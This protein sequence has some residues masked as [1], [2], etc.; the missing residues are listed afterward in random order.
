MERTQNSETLS[1]LQEELL[2]GNLQRE[3]VLALLNEGTTPHRRGQS[4]LPALGVFGAVVCFTGLAVLVGQHWNELGSLMRIALT[5]GSGLIAYGVG[6]LLFLEKDAKVFATIAFIFSMLL[7]PSGLAV[8]LHE[9]GYNLGLDSCQLFMAVT[10]FLA[11]IAP[12]VIL[13]SN[14]MLV[15]AIAAGTAVFFVATDMLVRG[16]AV[17]QHFSEYRA[18][19]TGLFYVALG[20]VLREGEFRVT[21]AGLY[22]V[23]SVVALGAGFSLMQWKPNQNIVW[24]LLYPGLACAAIYGGAELR[25]RAIMVNGAFALNA[26]IIKI[27]VQYF[28]VSIG[29]PLTMI[30]T[31]AG[32]VGVALYASNLYGAPQYQAANTNDA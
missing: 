27:S 30:L 2:S 24:E 19:F 29:W 4:W 22:T 13:R 21:S 14:A 7:L 28:S 25:S 8:T 9:A 10:L 5:L 18:L 20:T 17:P 1:K 12:A 31:G 11:F 16:I 23:G 6:L 15:G 3:Q 32:I 26:Y